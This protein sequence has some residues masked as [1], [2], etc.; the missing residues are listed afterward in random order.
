MTWE[1]GSLGGTRAEDQLVG[2]DQFPEE[3]VKV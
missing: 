1:V 3:P 2:S